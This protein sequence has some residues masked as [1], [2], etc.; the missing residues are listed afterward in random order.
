MPEFAIP[1]DDQQY[2]S[3]NLSETSYAE[4]QELEELKKIKW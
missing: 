1:E 2:G 3:L 4:E